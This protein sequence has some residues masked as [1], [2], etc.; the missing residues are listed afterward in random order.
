MG[1]PP[2]KNPP[3]SGSEGSY[4]YPLRDTYRGRFE[5]ENAAQDG[6]LDNGFKGTAGGIRQRE[7]ATKRD[8]ASER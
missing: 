4:R 8:Q 6:Q 5:G 3:C 7:G 2:I 1:I